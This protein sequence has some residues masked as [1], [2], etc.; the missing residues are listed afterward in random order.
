MTDKEKDEDEAVGS[1]L[2]HFEMIIQQA[3]QTARAVRVLYEALIN[4]GFKNTEALDIIK[5][6]GL[7][8]FPN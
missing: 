8:F 4:E 7:N 1:M 3:G 5:A 2:F 6:R